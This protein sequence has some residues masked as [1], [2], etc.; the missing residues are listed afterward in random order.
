MKKILFLF[1]LS[2][3]L[4]SSLFASDWSGRYL[5]VNSTT[6]DNGGKMKSVEFIVKETNDEWNREI[7]LVD[8]GVEYRLFPLILPTDASFSEWHKYKEDSAEAETFRH[9]NKKI[10]T[11]PFTPGKWMLSEILS[12]DVES[13]SEIKVS[14]FN[15][16]VGVTIT[17]SFSLDEKGKEQLT[18][19]METDLA[20][21]D[22]MFFKNPEPGSDGRFVLVKQI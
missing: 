3:F 17:F 20:M 2:I 8:E 16:K 14:A 5:W 18:F 1:V 15:L 22:G 6:K 7:Y 19:W 11:S 13:I 10:N 4:L 9:N 12:T 21:A